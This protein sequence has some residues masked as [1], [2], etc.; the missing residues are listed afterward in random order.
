MKIAHM[1]AHVI[2][3]I[4]WFLLC[5]FFQ[6]KIFSFTFHVSFAF[7]LYTLGLLI[8]TNDVYNLDFCAGLSQAGGAGQRMIHFR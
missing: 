2:F 5:A 7:M 3:L 6:I 8:E 4:F 1:G